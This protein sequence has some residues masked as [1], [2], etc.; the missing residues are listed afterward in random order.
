MQDAEAVQSFPNF[1][2]VHRRSPIAHGSKR[3]TPL[4]ERLEKAVSD[5]LG[6]LLQIPLQVTGKPRAV[7]ERAEQHWRCQLGARGEHFP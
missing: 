5:I 4:L 7:V 3:Q 6:V 1:G 2:G